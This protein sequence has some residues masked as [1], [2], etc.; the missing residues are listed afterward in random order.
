MV[1][2]DNPYPDSSYRSVL[3]PVALLF[4]LGFACTRVS[5]FSG[6]YQYAILLFVV[7][8][9][10]CF[11]DRGLIGRERLF[12][13]PSSMAQLVVGIIAAVALFFALYILMR[14]TRNIAVFSIFYT[15]GG[16]LSTGELFATVVVLFPVIEELLFRGFIQRNLTASFGGA[17]GMAIASAIGI[18]FCLVLTRTL[19]VLVPLSALT[20]VSGFLYMRYRSLPVTIAAHGTFKLLLFI[21]V[22]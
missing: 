3:A 10:A 19:W 6:L 22:L 17:S 7:I 8:L 12:A 14:V 5:F 1:K 20:L 16:A 21:F 4:A 9:V 11:F 15:A 13:L 2:L 18:L